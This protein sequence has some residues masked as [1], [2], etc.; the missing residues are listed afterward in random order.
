MNQDECNSSQRD[1]PSTQMVYNSIRI[2]NNPSTEDI[3]KDLNSPI[4]S[5]RELLLDLESYK[6]I[7]RLN[8]FGGRGRNVEGCRWMIRSKKYT[9]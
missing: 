7:R 2:G 8:G 9:G 1:N 4:D 3:A 6:G 5:I